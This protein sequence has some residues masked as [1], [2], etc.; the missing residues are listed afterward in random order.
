MGI[1][2]FFTIFTCILVFMAYIKNFQSI[3]D[4]V[5]HWYMI[6]HSVEI[7]LYVIYF[8][9]RRHIYVNRKCAAVLL[10]VLHDI[11]L[12]AIMLLIVSFN[13]YMYISFTVIYYIIFVC[14]ILAKKTEHGNEEEVQRSSLPR[15]T[16]LE[17]TELNND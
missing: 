15:K 3:G 11:F 12:I 7:L 2:F 13:R 6:A 10:F 16:F 8:A 14:I 5:P 9:T 17:M 1:L 4:P